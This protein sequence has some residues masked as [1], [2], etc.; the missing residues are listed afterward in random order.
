MNGSNLF[1]IE[2]LVPKF[3]YS[4]NDPT[5]HWQNGLARKCR[6]RDFI[7]YVTINIR[8]ILL[9]VIVKFRIISPVDLRNIHDQFS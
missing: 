4:F 6:L 7:D 3:V 2:V 1:G 9:L 8:E 5:D